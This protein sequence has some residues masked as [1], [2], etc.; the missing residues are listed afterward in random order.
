MDEL[1]HERVLGVPEL[2]DCSL[3]D[4]AAPIYHGHVVCQIECTFDVVAYHH[5]GCPRS[6]LDMLDED[7]DCAGYHRIQSAGG[8]VEQEYLGVQGQC[9]GQ[10]DPL[11]HTTGKLRRHLVLDSR[12]THL[13]QET[14]NLVADLLLRVVRMDNEGKTHV[15][16]HVHRVEQGRVLK[17]DPEVFPDIVELDLIHF[18]YIFIVDDDAAGIRPDETEDVLQEN[19]FPRP[20]RADNDRCFSLGNIQVEAVENRLALEGL[21]QRLYLDHPSP[22]QVVA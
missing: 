18:D 2:I 1:S 17:A 13:P 8:L 14:F 12:E 7:V 3:E 21:R 5:T 22:R 16:S 19:A 20:A 10:A 4:D 9:P 11:P 15:L 6:L